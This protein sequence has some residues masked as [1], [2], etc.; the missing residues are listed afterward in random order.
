MVA[1]A[2][3]GSTD[4]PART[5][6]GAAAG[7]TTSRSAIPAARTSGP[8]RT[9]HTGAVATTIWSVSWDPTGSSATPGAIDWKAATVL[10]TSMAERVS[11][12]VTA[13]V[14]LTPVSASS[15]RDCVDAS[16]TPRPTAW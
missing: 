6:S 13:V 2:A 14:D 8:T 10:I 5:G 11:T 12:E 3:T 16:L 4:G 9:P 7:T 15:G 1:R